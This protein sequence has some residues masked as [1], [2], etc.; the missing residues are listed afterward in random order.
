[1]IIPPACNTSLLE[2]TPLPLHKA[3]RHARLRGQIKSIVNI[4]ILMLCHMAANAT[5]GKQLSTPSH[6]DDVVQRAST[7]KG[8]YVAPQLASISTQ[9]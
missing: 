1:M 5:A 9:P 6:A 7:L 8:I 4:L 3:R 2:N